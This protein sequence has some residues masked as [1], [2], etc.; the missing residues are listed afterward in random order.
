MEL[1]VNVPSAE[2]RRSPKEQAA[3]PDLSCVED[4]VLFGMRLC[5]EGEEKEGWIPVMTEYRYKGWVR[6]G[7]CTFYSREKETEA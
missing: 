7:D 6:R 5:A 1:I 2:I 3:R 4:E